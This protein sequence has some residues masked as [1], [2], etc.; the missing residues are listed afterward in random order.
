MVGQ[1]SALVEQAVDVGRL[2][3]PRTSSHRQHVVNHPIGAVP[4][5]A[6]TLEVAGQISRNL[7][8]QLPVVL[9][10]L[11]LVVGEDLP[12]FLQQLL[13]DLREILD[14]VEWILDLVGYAG[15]E[16][17]EFRQL[18]AHDDLILSLAQIVHGFLELG[19]LPLQ[20]FGQFL[21]KVQALNLQGVTSKHLQ[22]RRH[23]GHLVA[24]ADL[25]LGLQVASG[26]ATHAIGQLLETAQQESSDEQPTDQHGAGDTD[27][28]QDQEQ[29][30]SGEDGLSGRES[31]ILGPRTGRT[32]HSFDFSHEID[33]ESAIALQQF[34]LSIGETE[35]LGPQIESILLPQTQF[36]QAVE[37]RGDP[38]PQRSTAE[39]HE[40]SP[41]TVAGRLEALPYRLDQGDFRQIGDARQKLGRIGRMR[42]Q[43]NH[44]A[45]AVELPFREVS[46]RGGG[47]LAKV[48]VAGQRIEV[49][50]IDGRHQDAGQCVLQGFK[51]RQQCRAAV[52][53]PERPGNRIPDGPDVRDDFTPV[54]KNA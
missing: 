7:L 5:L 28:V 19:V 8:E 44:V 4:V 15:G 11:V 33:G 40:A 54:G 1:S 9:A 20:L 27:Q 24:P 37:D 30:A 25:D 3:L 26:H 49:M 10:Q 21:D 22:G 18:V 12:Q 35:L 47:P 2:P 43:F 23:L 39:S 48:P 6:N 31:R 41:D 36:Q 14:E 34:A 46:R 29:A 45:V 32:H 42:L 38:V 53:Q 13:G 16:L 50:V 51:F 17:A 52:V